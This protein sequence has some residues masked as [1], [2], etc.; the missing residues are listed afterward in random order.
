MGW[1]DIRHPFEVAA[2]ERIAAERG[3][4][5]VSPA[6]V[7]VPAE[8][9]VPAATD[10][11]AAIW[12][13]ANRIAAQ[14]AGLV[15]GKRMSK[16]GAIADRI[17]AKKAAHDA[18]ADEWGARLDALDGREP[19]AFAIGDAVIAEREGDLAEMERTMRSLSNLPNVVSDGSLKG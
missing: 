11:T 15:E 7:V 4:V 8:S 5:V 6:A 1:R 2:D 9:V 12:H 17:A 18:K 10:I 3:G 14:R 16:L 19:E 13:S